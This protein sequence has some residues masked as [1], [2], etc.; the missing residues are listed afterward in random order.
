MKHECQPHSSM[1]LPVWQKW[2]SSWQQYEAHMLACLPLP[3]IFNLLH[4]C[5]QIHAKAEA[6]AATGQPIT[7]K[8]RPMGSGISP[9]GLSQ[10]DAGVVSLAQLDKVP[11]ACRCCH[12]QRNQSC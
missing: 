3:P 8:I 12:V 11:R 1:N 6:Q 10:C 5:K 9:N 4:G 2:S 7:H